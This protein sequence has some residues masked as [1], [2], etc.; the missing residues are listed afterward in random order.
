[1]KGWNEIQPSAQTDA[2]TYS[3]CIAGSEVE[4]RMMAGKDA[5]RKVL[6]NMK[7]S[8]YKVRTCELLH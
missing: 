8:H 6:G 2:V 5:V 7:R 3:V 1:M 4:M